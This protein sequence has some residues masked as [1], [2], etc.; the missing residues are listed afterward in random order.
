MMTDAASRFWHSQF[1]NLEASRFPPLLGT[2]YKT[3]HVEA[4]HCVVSATGKPVSGTTLAAQIQ[5]AWSILISKYTDSTDVI[6]GIKI[7]NHDAQ[8]KVLPFRF[9][10]Q[11]DVTVESASEAIEYQTAAMACTAGDLTLEEIGALSEEAAA[12]CDFQYLLDID[13]LTRI[14][15]D[16]DN[17]SSYSHPCAL[18]IICGIQNG[19]P[20]DSGPSLKFSVHHDPEVIKTIEA[21]RM[22]Q[23]FEHILHQLHQSPQTPLQEVKTISAV[24]WAILEDW[25]GKVPKASET[26]L[27]ELAFRHRD[28]RPALCAWDGELSYTQMNDASLGIAQHLISSGIKSGIITLFCMEKSQ[29]AVITLLSILRVG[30]VCVPIDPNTPAGR[31][32]EMIEDVGAEFVVVSPGQCGQMEDMGPPITVV[33]EKNEEIALDTSVQLPQVQPEDLAFILF[34]SGSTGRAKAMCIEHRNLTTALLSWLNTLNIHS[35]TRSLQFA[36]YSFDLA[37]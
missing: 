1:L 23:Q 2:D 32:R 16:N 18:T 34:T 6:F 5:L 17:G 37:I 14:G 21:L 12:A 29:L 22:V 11:D 25:N 36:S 24:D 13:A 28:S 7:R 33:S 31:T 19:S 27:H 30:A 9:H 20:E 8:L 15:L 26:T 3:A 4:L 10:I 35:T